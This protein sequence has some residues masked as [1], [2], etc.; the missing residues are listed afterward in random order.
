MG[1]A[2]TGNPNRRTG[3]TPNLHRV[4][5]TALARESAVIVGELAAHHARLA[6][7]LPSNAPEGSAVFEE[8]G[9]APAPRDEQMLELAAG[10]RTPADH[11][12]L[13]EYVADLAARYDAE[14]RRH[15][16]MAAA[17]RGNPRSSVSSAATHCDRLVRT[18]REAGAE[19]R[20]Q[21]SEHRSLATSTVR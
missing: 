6:S 21:A 19:A 15:T 1:R 2:L 17:Y 9:G 14:T 20:A 16:A 4:R 5:L 8:G 18:A 10:A 12:L 13:E 3:T 11:A 7:G